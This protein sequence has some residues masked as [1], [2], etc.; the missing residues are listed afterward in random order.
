MV[1]GYLVPYLKVV[2]NRIAEAQKAK[3]ELTRVE[4]RLRV[5]KLSAGCNLRPP[6]N[7][8]LQVTVEGKP[9]LLL[10]T[11]AE[12]DTEPRFQLRWLINA[13]GEPAGLP[14][15]EPAAAN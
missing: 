12:G 15:P 5:S 3:E 1:P 10:V 7:A 6:F 9:A 8:A 2:A 13:S 11:Y 14:D 4:G